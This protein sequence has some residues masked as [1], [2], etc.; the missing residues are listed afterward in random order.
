MILF[1]WSL[2]EQDLEFFAVCGILKA[3][4]D[5][6]EVPPHPNKGVTGR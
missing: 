1:F 4:A 5:P 6:L 3:L 2:L